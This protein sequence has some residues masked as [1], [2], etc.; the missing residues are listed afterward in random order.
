M[1]IDKMVL[2]GHSLG[3]YLAATYALQHPQHVQHLLLVCP[4]GIVRP[5]CCGDCGGL[6]RAPPARLPDASTARPAE[7]VH[8]GT[9]LSAKPCPDVCMRA[10]WPQMGHITA[11]R[12]TESC[13]VLRAEREA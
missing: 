5:W 13:M 6:R 12:V 1:G 7:A 8:S 9:F 2:V 11:A 10:C 3:G 4:A